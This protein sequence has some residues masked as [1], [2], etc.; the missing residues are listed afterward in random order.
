MEEG[1]ECDEEKGEGENGVGHLER[2]V[3][4]LGWLGTVE[5]EGPERKTERWVR[6]RR[7]KSSRNA[8]IQEAFSGALENG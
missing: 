3:V 6:R 5:N 1:R 8:V 4:A 2:K 7:M